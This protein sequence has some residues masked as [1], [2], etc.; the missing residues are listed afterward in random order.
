[1]LLVVGVALVLVMGEP[2][3]A[4][5][6]HRA[7]EAHKDY[8][9]FKVLKELVLKEPKELLVLQ[10][11]EPKELSVFKVRTVLTA[12]PLRALMTLLKALQISTLQLDVSHMNTLKEPPV[13]PG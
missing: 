2:S 13:T 5:K 7:L 9:E 4:L 1:M 10:L 3:Q 12:L 6:V 11:K 8:K